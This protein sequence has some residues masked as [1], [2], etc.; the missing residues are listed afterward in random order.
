MVLKAFVLREIKELTAKL[1]RLSAQRG[2]FSGFDMYWF[3]KRRTSQL[4]FLHLTNRAEV[5]AKQLEMEGWLPMSDWWKKIWRY[6]T[7]S[8]DV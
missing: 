4:P 7:H 1:T 6:F 5:K 2:N 8:W 3:W